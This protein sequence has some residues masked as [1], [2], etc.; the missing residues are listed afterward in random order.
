MTV[1]WSDYERVHADRRNLRIHLLAVPLFQSGFVLSVIFLMAGQFLFAAVSV[2]AAVGGMV[3][4]KIGHSKATHEV[5][6]FSGP[7]NFLRRWFTEQF[8][9]F[10]IF[11][12]SGRWQRQ[13]KAD[14]V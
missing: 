7:L 9:T 14:G 1:D 2:L 8:L 4:Q 5:R 10:P 11:V 13:Y 3:L 12:F 6:P